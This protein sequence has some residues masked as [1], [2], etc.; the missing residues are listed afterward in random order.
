[1]SVTTLTREW[2][3][4]THVRHILWCSSHVLN[5]CHL[6]L[7]NKGDVASSMPIE[8]STLDQGRGREAIQTHT[9]SARHYFSYSLNKKNRLGPK[10]LCLWTFGFGLDSSFEIS[11][12]WYSQSFHLTWASNSSLAIFSMKS[13]VATVGFE[14][15]ALWE[16][17]W[18]PSLFVE[19]CS[20]SLLRL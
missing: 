17:P 1:M 7:L 9:F 6:M 18:F 20:H 19:L 11:N 16:Y 12:L 5:T 8:I 3:S 14:L 13:L 4:Y 15:K 2:G 10:A